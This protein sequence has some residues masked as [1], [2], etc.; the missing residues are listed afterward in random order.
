M[1]SGTCLFFPSQY[2][3]LVQGGEKKKLKCGG[4]ASAGLVNCSGLW[5]AQAKHCSCCKGRV[6]EEP[7]AWGARVEKKGGREWYFCSKLLM[8]S[9][10]F[11]TL[12][13]FSRGCT[14]AAFLCPQHL[15]K[16]SQFTWVQRE[17]EQ[18]CG[19]EIL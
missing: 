15:S 10:D 9:Q 18:V 6:Q 17:I 12:T 5:K 14:R 16:R 13:S 2:I 1:S 7:F 11:V 3:L 4:V 19:R 8:P